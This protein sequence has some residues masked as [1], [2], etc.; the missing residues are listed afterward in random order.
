MELS[1]AFLRSTLVLAV[2]GLSAGSALA[3]Q[4]TYWDQGNVVGSGPDS[5]GNYFSTVYDQAPVSST[6]SSSGYITYD[7][8]EGAA[9]GLKVVSDAPPLTKGDPVDN[10]IMAAG[11]ATCNGPFQSGKRFK[12][13]Q[14]GAGPID[15]VFGMSNDP[16]SEGNDGLYKIFQKYGNNTDVALT[17][18]SIGLGFGV[19]EAFTSS[20]DQD[21][22]SF[23]DFGID[24][25]NNQFSSLFSQGLFGED[26]KRGR[27]LGYFSDERSGFDLD[28]V[29]EDLFQTTGLFGGEYGYGSLFSNWLAY[30]MAPEGYYFDDDGD[31]LTEGVL[32]AHFNSEIGKWIMNREIDDSGEVASVHFGNEGTQYDTVADVEAALQA[33]AVASGLTLAQCSEAAVPGTPCLAGTEAIEDLAKFNVTSFIDAFNF[34]AANKPTF[35]MRINPSM[36]VAVPEPGSLALLFAGIGALLMRRRMNRHKAITV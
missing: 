12:L 13:D 24:P 14:T 21:G 3:A 25:K 26:E 10:C 4:I 16:L 36:M 17:G 1:K 31:P 7:L 27:L 23:V 9:P 20:T 32:M 29:G 30:S 19:G 28:L 8:D 33:Q 34:D 15:L 5:D 6:A 18:F 11:S 35:T 22:L 2:S